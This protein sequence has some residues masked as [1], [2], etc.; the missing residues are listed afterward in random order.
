MNPFSQSSRGDRPIPASEGFYSRLCPI[1]GDEHPPAILEELACRMKDSDAKREARGDRVEAMMSGY[2]YLGQFIDHDL[3]RDETLLRDAKPNVTDTPNFRTPRLDLD[4]LYGKVPADVP[5]VYQGRGELRIDSTWPI[6]TPPTFNDLPRNAAGTAEV[7]DSRSDENLIIS[8]IHVLFAK[9]HNQLLK[10]GGSHPELLKGVPGKDAF[11]KTRRLV[12]WHYQWII[13]N[14]FLPSFVQ[15]HVLEMVFQKRQLRLFPRIYTPKDAPIALPVEF[16]VAAYRFG[17]SM[18]QEV[19]LLNGE[20]LVGTGTLIYMTKRGGGIGGPPPNPTPPR[21]LADYVVDWDF[22]FRAT[23]TELNRGQNIDTFI[24]EVLYELPPE[25]IALFRS[26]G[27][28]R[29]LKEFMMPLPELTLKRGSKI[30]LPSGEQFAGCFGFPKIGRTDIP[31]LPE[32]R[33]FFDN[34]EFHDR[35]PLW[36]Y[37]LREASLEM[38]QEPEPGNPFGAPIQKLGSIGSQ[39]VAEVFFQVLATDADSILNAGRNWQ[40]PQFVFGSSGSARALDTM[41]NVVDFIQAI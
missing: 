22:F 7:V 3:T 41:P 39:I 33:A 8:Q 2:V 27:A 23:D 9:L 18:V 28:P 36:Y 24:T 40:P 21:L 38:T 35:T 11:E 29:T 5:N 10:L 31:A 1:E 13:A 26:A 16:T 17:H 19:Y 6:T 30:H 34:A 12:T 14:D 37:L 4:H 32:D 20:H 25:T 15:T